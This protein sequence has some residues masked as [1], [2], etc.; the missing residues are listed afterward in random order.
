MYVCVCVYIYITFGDKGLISWIYSR[1]CTRVFH[2]NS[3][4]TSCFYIQHVCPSVSLQN[5]Y[6]GFFFV[7]TNYCDISSVNIMF[8]LYWLFVTFWLWHACSPTD[9]SSWYCYTKICLHFGGAYS[10]YG[11]EI[12]CN[13][14]DGLLH[15][16]QGERVKMG[17]GFLWNTGVCLLDYI[18][19]SS[20]STAIFV[21]FYT[22]KNDNVEFRDVSSFSCFLFKYR[23]GVFMKVELYFQHWYKC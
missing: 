18:H 11:T 15:H 7:N 23:A 14:L 10:K 4:H 12:F 2:Q 6:P 8:K 5:T 17:A 16:L 9:L 21:G 13:T 3:E 1:V 20:Q 19:A 22:A